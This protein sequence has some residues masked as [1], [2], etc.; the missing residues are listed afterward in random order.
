MRTKTT[1]EAAKD[2]AKE[3]AES[4]MR[5]PDQH[6]PTIAACAEEFLVRFAEFWQSEPLRSTWGAR[7][8]DKD[9][10][11]ALSFVAAS[12]NL[13]AAI[14]GIPMQSKFEIKSIAGNIIPAIATTNAIV[15]GFEVRAERGWHGRC[16][17]HAELIIVLPGRKTGLI[18]RAYVCDGQVLEAIK[19]V[20]PDA[21]VRRDC[22]AT[23]IAQEPVGTW[24]AWSALIGP[25]RLTN[26]GLLSG[27][28]RS[29]AATAC[30]W[31]AAATEPAVHG[32]SVQYAD[33]QAGHQKD[34]IQAFHCRSSEERLVH[35]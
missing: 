26:H 8:F 15:A 1:S 17:A 35:E 33:R 9:D 27:L 31:A 12:A 5:L 3:A 32:V 29:L 11:H 14:F 13:R 6:V 22:S 23:F 19:L 20:K 10:N 7:T 16:T 2:A 25:I 34:N 21:D 24:I 28:R 18:S 30:G 4:A